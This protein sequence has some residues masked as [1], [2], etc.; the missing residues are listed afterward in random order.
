MGFR[1]L[2]R[3]YPIEEFDYQ[4]LMSHLSEYVNKRDKVTRLVNSGRIIRVKKGIYVF[5]LDYR[6]GLVSKESLANVIYGPSYISY[7]YALSFY[8][9]IPE[10]VEVVT[11]ATTG[12]SR[13]FQ[14]PIGSFSYRHLSLQKYCVGT[15]YLRIDDYHSIMIASPEKALLDQTAAAKGLTQSISIGDYLFGDLRI[16]ESFLRRF[17]L[18]RLR[19]IAMEYFSSKVSRVVKFLEEGHYHA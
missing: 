19:K 2:R 7:E 12:R 4:L 8:G 3:E 17:S 5:G 14:T 18:P 16:E 9:L 11:S 10:R 13:F 15:T 6:K 1:D